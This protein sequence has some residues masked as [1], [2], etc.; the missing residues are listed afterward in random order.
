MYF[1]RKKLHAF[2]IIRVKLPN[3]NMA[4]SMQNAVAKNVITRCIDHGDLGLTCIKMPTCL[5]GPRIQNNI[6]YR[7]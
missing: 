3:K 2:Y 5:K 1:E 7:R 6:T 4:F